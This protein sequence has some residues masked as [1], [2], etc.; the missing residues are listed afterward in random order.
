MKTTGIESISRVIMVGI[1]LAAAFTGL[2]ADRVA[3]SAGLWHGAQKSEF[4]TISFMDHLI[5]DS[6]LGVSGGNILMD[7]RG[8]NTTSVPLSAYYIGST[9][10]KDALAGM[11]FVVGFNWV[12][13]KTVYDYSL[14]GTG[15]QLGSGS[16]ASDVQRNTDIEAGI[17]LPLSEKKIWL[18]LRIGKRMHDYR[19]KFEES[20]YITPGMTDFQD[21]SPFV[22]KATGNLIIAD[23]SFEINPKLNLLAGYKMIGQLNGNVN[24]TEFGTFTTTGPSTF[25]LYYMKN[26]SQYA[27]RGNETMLGV[28]YRI[29]PA[30]KIQLTYR[31]ETLQIKYPGYFN[32]FNIMTLTSGG[33]TAVT[34][35]LVSRSDLATDYFFYGSGGTRE[36][37]FL[38][39]GVTYD[40]DLGGGSR[41]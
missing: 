18:G 15:P 33:V 7:W 22:A 20:S 4:E 30:V 34:A 21:P 26:E 38:Y 1:L 12:Q 5:D 9:N 10:L 16:Y 27:V 19:T 14:I 41:R 39:L 8:K 37:G 23:F 29:S 3:L 25:S 31:K 35:G 13:H 2:H 28:E 36:K 40:L 17:R 11:E 32:R 6:A 24:F